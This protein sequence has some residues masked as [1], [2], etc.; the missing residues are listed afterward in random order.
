LTIVN[1]LFKL[2][3]WLISSMNMGSRPSSPYWN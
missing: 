3:G 2:T 1:S